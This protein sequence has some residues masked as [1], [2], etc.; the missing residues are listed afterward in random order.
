ME[1]DLSTVLNDTDGDVAMTDSHYDRDG[2]RDRDS[3]DLRERDRDLRERDVSSR[4]G[5]RSPGKEGPTGDAAPGTP[6]EHYSSRPRSPRGDRYGAS[7][8]RTPY[9]RPGGDSEWHN[10]T[11][12]SDLPSAFLFYLPVVT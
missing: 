7:R 4:N 3:R 10:L 2:D 8:L 12:H 11:M 5:Y 9:E 6:P 1:Q